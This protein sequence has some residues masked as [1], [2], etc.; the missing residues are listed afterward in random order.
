MRTH[1]NN[2]NRGPGGSSPEASLLQTLERLGL[3][4]PRGGAGGA[5]GRRGGGA[6]K[7]K[8]KVRDARQLL[9]DQEAEK[10]LSG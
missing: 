4:P 2:R 1:M 8:M 7:Q 3:T 5:G 9:V 10:W 6:V